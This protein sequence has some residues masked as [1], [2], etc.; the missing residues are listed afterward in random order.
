M[1]HD[2][3]D[4]LQKCKVATWTLLQLGAYREAIII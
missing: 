1:L 3:L 2:I 4:L